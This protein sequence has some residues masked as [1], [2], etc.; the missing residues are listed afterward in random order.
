LFILRNSNLLNWTIILYLSLCSTTSNNNKIKLFKLFI[1][2]IIIDYFST[3]YSQF[4]PW[5]PKIIIIILIHYAMYN[6]YFKILWREQTATADELLTIIS[7]RQYNITINV[8]FVNSSFVLIAMTISRDIF[9]W[10]F[11]K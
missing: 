6:S 2:I 5:T 7:S 9:I 10:T 4:T 11:F 3:R 8:S 1:I